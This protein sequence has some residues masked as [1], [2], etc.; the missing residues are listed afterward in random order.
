VNAIIRKPGGATQIA[1][2]S[3]QLAKTE[4]YCKLGISAQVVLASI[5]DR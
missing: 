2:E 1:W 5:A 4:G 3:H